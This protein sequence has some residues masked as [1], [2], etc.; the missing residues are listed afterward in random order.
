MRMEIGPVSGMRGA[1]WGSDGYIL[2][3]RVA[4][5]VYGTLG[6]SA[7]GI[8][9]IYRISAAGGEV[10][11][12]TVPDPSRGEL[13]YLWPQVLPE[14]R[15]LYW[16]QT[17]KPEDS[18]I[19]VAP[20]SKPGKRVKLLSTESKSVYASGANGKGYILWVRS[21][22]LVAQEFNPHTL[23]LAGEPRQIVESLQ[24]TREGE[25]YVSASDTG[26]LLYGK[27][28]ELMQF[29]WWDRTGHQLKELGSPW[30]VSHPASSVRLRMIGVSQS[31]V[32]QAAYKTSG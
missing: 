31:R 32:F 8:Y 27:S 30:S 12:V 19:F 13:A 23:R 9:G 6:T 16:V 25:V 21:G 20:L 29:A 11:A 3:S 4:T 14:G 15:F 10:S 28:E 22:S 24:Q 1:S 2:F 26:L 5:G 7:R 17:A 18:G